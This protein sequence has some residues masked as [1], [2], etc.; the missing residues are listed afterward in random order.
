[1]PPKIAKLPM[2]MKSVCRFVYKHFDAVENS[3]REVPPSR[4][5]LQLF[6]PMC[7]DSCDGDSA[8][9]EQ[10]PWKLAGTDVHCHP[11]VVQLLS[12]ANIAHVGGECDL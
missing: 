8:C 2:H 1:M 6:L 7:S 9:E 4:K 5:P 12:A 10:R 3:V 11:L